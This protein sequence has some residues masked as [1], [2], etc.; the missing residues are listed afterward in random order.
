MREDELEFYKKKLGAMFIRWLRFVKT[1]I[2]YATK[3]GCY[4]V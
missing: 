4:R 2:H 3:I 1:V